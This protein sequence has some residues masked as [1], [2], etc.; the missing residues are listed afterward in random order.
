MDNDLKILR[1]NAS[2]TE[3]FHTSF[4]HLLGKDFVAL[5]W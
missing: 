1:C 4:F 3:L 5:F 2:A